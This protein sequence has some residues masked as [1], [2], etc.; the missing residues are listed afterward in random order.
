MYVFHLTLYR[1]DGG[2]LSEEHHST[3]F[4]LWNRFGV[5]R[6]SKDDQTKVSRSIVICQIPQYVQLTKILQCS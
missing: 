4:T 6:P 3:N 5:E 1:N 2:V